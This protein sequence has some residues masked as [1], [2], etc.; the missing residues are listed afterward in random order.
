M[1]RLCDSDRLWL[2]ENAFRPD[3]TYKY[4]QREE[5][6]KK[7]S[8]QSAWLLQ[9]S[10]LCYSESC[11]GGFCVFCFLF[12]KPHFPLGQL[13]T[14]PMVNFTRAK[15]TLQEHSRQTSHVMAS[16]DAIDFKNHMERGAPS[17]QQLLQ[18]Q[19][20]A[21]VKSNRLKILSLLKTIIFCGRQMI[22]LRGHLEQADTNSVNPGNFRA[23]LDFHIDPATPF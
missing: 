10:W 9:F 2:L 11:N 19:A 7:C 23:L 21:L 5:Y 1:A 8:F 15:L 12:A 3:A 13:V 18:N 16:M 14:S 4:P 22:P 20:S 17:V 6:G